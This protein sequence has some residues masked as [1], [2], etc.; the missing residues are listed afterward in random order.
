MPRGGRETMAKDYYGKCG[1]C[2]HCELGTGYTSLYSTSFTCSRNNYSVK[3]DEKPCNKFEPALGRSN[4]MIE[5][6]NK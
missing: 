2:K 1:S 4:A 6:Y 3:A 5:K